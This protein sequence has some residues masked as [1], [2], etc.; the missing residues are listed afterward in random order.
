LAQE[1]GISGR[2]R[3]HGRQSRETIAEAMRRCAVFALPSSYEGLGCVYLEAMASGRPAI[4][5]RG[6]GIEEIIEHGKSGFLISPG[7]DAELSEFLRVLLQNDDF[8]SRMGMNA[9]SAVLQRHTLEHQAE[10]LTEVYR[11]CVR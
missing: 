9:R 10:Q 2:V 3:F 7:N 1:I 6:Q 11:E 4:G 8:R 5:C